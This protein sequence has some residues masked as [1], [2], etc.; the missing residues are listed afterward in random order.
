MEG[1]DSDTSNFVVPYRAIRQ[2]AAFNL[3]KWFVLGNRHKPGQHQA[4]LI[5]RA[6]S[7]ARIARCVEVRTW[8]GWFRKTPRRAYGDTIAVLDSYVAARTH[9]PHWTLDVVAPQGRFFL[10]LVE[11]GLAASL[12]KPI[13]MK[14]PGL[15]LIRRALDYE[16]LSRIHLHIDAIESAAM[17]EGN[18]EATWELVKATAAKRVLELIHSRWCPRRGTVYSELTPDLE[19]AWQSAD[20]GERERIRERYRRFKPDRFA[21]DRRRAPRPNWSVVGVETDIAPHNVYRLLLALAGDE[22]FLVA[23][24]LHVWALDLVSAGL[25]MHA[26]AW[27]DRYTTHGGRVSPEMVYWAALEAVFFSDEP[28]CAVVTA[29]AAAFNVN[30]TDFNEVA[31]V[32]LYRARESYRHLLSMLHVDRKSLGALVA[33]CWQARPIVYRERRPDA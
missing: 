23:D 28:D 10:D 12:M 31:A 8:Q 25:A 30:K 33:R 5:H 17:S 27:T 9:P 11:G 19:L 4:A 26:L 13:A 7:D 3:F 16:P 29:I 20:A 22:D 1:F 24:R 21:A 2:P 14:Q 6:M 18:G 32:N 15:A